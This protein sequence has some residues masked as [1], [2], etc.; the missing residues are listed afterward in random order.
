VLRTGHGEKEKATLPH[1][2]FGLPSADRKNRAAAQL[3]PA[4]LRQCSPTAPDFSAHPRRCRRG[5]LSKV[6]PPHRIC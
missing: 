1:R 3:G 2:P 5:F 4:G 6:I